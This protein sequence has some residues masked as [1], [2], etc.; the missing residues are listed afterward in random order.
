[1]TSR[2]IACHDILHEIFLHLSP[3]QQPEVSLWNA[4]HDREN[5]S[6]LT[7][8]A[9]FLVSK[10]ARI[11]TRRASFMLCSSSFTVQVR[12]K[13]CIAHPPAAAKCARAMNDK[14]TQRIGQGLRGALTVLDSEVN[15]SARAILAATPSSVESSPQIHTFIP[16]SERTLT[17][18]TR[19]HI[20]THKSRRLTP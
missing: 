15:A 18:L 5:R 8:T 10:R 19:T 1:M 7:K 14:I 13:S 17:T 16:A 9:L 20:E 12:L 11:D 4:E 6:K 2:A 3:T